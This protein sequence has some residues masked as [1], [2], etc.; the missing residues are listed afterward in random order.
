MLRTRRP[1]GADDTGAS[2]VEYSL[3]VA[4][5]AAIIV[6][7]VFAVGASTKRLFSDTCDSFKNNASASVSSATSCPP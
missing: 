2:A 3:I 6:A 1:R 5:I 4:A 7:I